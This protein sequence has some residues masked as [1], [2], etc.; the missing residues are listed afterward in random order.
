MTVSMPLT[1]TL[2]KNNIQTM[3]K[4]EKSSIK[5]ILSI[6]AMSFLVFWVA[7][8]IESWQALKWG[9]GSESVLWNV[10]RFD[11]GTIG[12]ISTVTLLNFVLLFFLTSLARKLRWIWFAFALLLSAEI[13]NLGRAHTKGSLSLSAPGINQPG[14]EATIGNVVDKFSKAFKHSIHGDS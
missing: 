10:L 11:T 12:F 6:A 7:A 4:H 8:C 2:R 5:D 13:F 1:N 14:P 3:K 9:Y